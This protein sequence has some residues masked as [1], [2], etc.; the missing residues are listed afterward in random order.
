LCFYLELF[1]DSKGVRPSF[2]RVQ[3]QGLCASLMGVYMCLGM[4]VRMRM[5]VCSLCVCSW[6]RPRVRACLCGCGCGCGCGGGCLGICVYLC[7]RALKDVCLAPSLSWS[8]S[9]HPPPPPA[10]C[11]RSPGPGAGPAGRGG[12]R[13][14]RWSLG[15]CSTGWWT[16][17]ASSAS[18]RPAP[19]PPSPSPPTA[20]GPIPRSLAVEPGGWTAGGERGLWRGMAA[21]RRGVGVCRSYELVVGKVCRS[22]EFVVGVQ[23]IKI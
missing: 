13:R 23:K 6:V 16:P 5:R 3:L 14:Q 12:T 18:P 1:F 4:C 21:E 7:E 22:Y 20:A 11:A 9:T 15:P 8:P 19:S 10:R 17:R 2:G